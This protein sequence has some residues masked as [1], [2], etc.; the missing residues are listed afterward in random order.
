MEREGGVGQPVH[1]GATSITTYKG[2]LMPNNYLSDQLAGN[3]VDNAYDSLISEF[4][5]VEAHCYS[6]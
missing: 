6:V 4:N 5:V 2:V 3:N 1:V